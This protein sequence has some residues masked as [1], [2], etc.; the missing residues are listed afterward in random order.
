MHSSCLELVD[1]IDFHTANPYSNLGLTTEKYKINKRKQS[2]VEN[3]KG[4]LRMSSKSLVDS[5]KI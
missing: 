1:V 3:V 5:E 2:E 4:T